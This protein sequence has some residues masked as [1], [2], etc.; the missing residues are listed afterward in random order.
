M[1]VGAIVPKIW[2]PLQERRPNQLFV[3]DDVTGR[4]RII[5]IPGAGL[6]DRSHYDYIVEAEVEKTKDELRKMGPKPVARLSRQEVAG[7]LREFISWR[8]KKKAD[9][10]Y[11]GVF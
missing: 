11:K 1:L 3:K 7:A 5:M 6:L 4:E 9:P 10:G 2:L 8:N